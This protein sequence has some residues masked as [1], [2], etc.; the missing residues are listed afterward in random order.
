MNDTY[1]K[2]DR[3]SKSFGSFRVLDDVSLELG[4]GKFLSILG[5]SGSGKTTILRI[6]SGLEPL[7]SGKVYIEDTDITHLPPEKRNINMV[8]QSYAL[9][10]HMTVA[11]NVGYSLKFLKLS[12]EEI[13]RRVANTLDMVGL[14]GMEARIPAQLSGG[15]RQRVAI[16][17]AVINEPKLL[18]L[19][20]PLGALDKSLRKKMQFKLKELQNRLGITCVYITH[21]QDEAMFLSDRI[22]VLSEGRF[23]QIDSPENIMNSDIPYVRDFLGISLE[24][25]E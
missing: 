13:K 22:A 8:F 14:L 3:V 17:R 9:F 23:I 16:A 5:A 2:I 21:D 25:K 24:K 1:L 6:I 12:K 15:Q 20:E 7:D 19:D 10:E 18:L 4:K 11:E